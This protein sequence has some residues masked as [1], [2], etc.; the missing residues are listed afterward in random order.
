MCDQFEPKPPVNGPAE[1]HFLIDRLPEQC[2][3][4]AAEVLNMLC[5][6]GIAFKV[7]SS[8]RFPAPL[9]DVDLMTQ[10]CPIEERARRVHFFARYEASCL[11]TA[12]IE[13]EHLLL[14][15]LREDKGLVH[16]LLGA[17]PRVATMD[18]VRKDIQGSA[19]EPRASNMAE[20]LPSKAYAEV[21]RL[22][23]VEAKRLLQKVAPVH[24][25][26]GL[27]VEKK[28]LAA[29]ILQRRGVTITNVRDAM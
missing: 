12:E 24:L 27:L 22:A 2:W 26:A 15:V 7:G 19:G 8:A 17:T 21:W 4:T 1:L 13:P 3:Q 28:S 9:S 23:A 25:V 16:H 20:L 10:P 5:E 11:G 6:T 14:G 18:A 29:E